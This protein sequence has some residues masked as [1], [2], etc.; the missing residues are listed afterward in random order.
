MSF[1]L[2]FI[3]GNLCVKFSM[4]CINSVPVS[5]IASGSIPRKEVRTM[6]NKQENNKQ[7]QQQ[8]QEQQQQN[9]QNKK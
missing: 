5:K 8:N 3:P 9:Q 4:L 6:K 7:N 2:F 1:L